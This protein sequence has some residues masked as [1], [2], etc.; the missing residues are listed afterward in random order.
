MKIPSFLGVFWGGMNIHHGRIVFFSSK[1]PCL[2]VQGFLFLIHD[3]Y[4]FFFIFFFGSGFPYLAHLHLC[5][6]NW[7]LLLWLSSDQMIG[8]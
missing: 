2:G 6:L 8:S 3:L 7:L 5:G 4:H 1:F